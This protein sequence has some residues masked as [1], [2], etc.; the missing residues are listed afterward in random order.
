[1]DATASNVQGPS[2]PQLLALVGTFR[3]TQIRLGIINPQ[4]GAFKEISSISQGF[5]LGQLFAN[6]T[7]QAL[8]TSVTNGV[9]GKGFA[10]SILKLDFKG[11]VQQT[12]TSKVSF[13]TFQRNPENGAFFVVSVDKSKG[14]PDVSSVN[15]T[16][17]SI[18]LVLDFPLGT[19]VEGVGVSGFINNTETFLVITTDLGQNQVMRLIDSTTWKTKTISWPPMTS[20]F[21]V[22]QSTNVV[23]A[24]VLDGNTMLTDIVSYDLD[25]NSN[26]VLGTAQNLFAGVTGSN[27]WDPVSQ[28]YFTAMT[29]NKGN[30]VLGSFNAETDKYT[31]LDL[32][33][34]PWAMTVCNPSVDLQE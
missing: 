33:Y 11:N 14:T 27:A 8:Y 31:E 10:N 12:L 24:T 34:V 20:S 13:L 17:K 21:V 25:T 7:E 22:D 1:V 5:V 18:S 3:G 9:F 6:Y 26:K 28:T 19:V 30:C 15:L 32:K 23:Y 29:D 2:P 4:N 16:S